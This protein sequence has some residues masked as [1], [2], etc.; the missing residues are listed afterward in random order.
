MTE[1]FEAFKAALD[2]LCKE[3][4][5]R[6]YEEWDYDDCQRVYI[7]EAGE[8]KSAGLDADIQCV[9]PPI[10]PTPEEVAAAAAAKAEWEAGAA[11]REAEY[12]ARMD[13]W[14]ALQEMQRAARIQSPEYL[15]LQVQIKAQAEEQRKKN[16]RVTRIPGDFHDIG[17]KACRV[18]C[19]EVEVSNWI[20]AD[21]F[22]RVVIVPGVEY[23]LLEMAEPTRLPDTVLHGAVRIELAA[24]PA[25]D[26][27]PAVL[28]PEGYVL[29][30]A[31]SRADGEPIACAASVQ[32]DPVPFV[33]TA[34]KPKRIPARKRK[35]GK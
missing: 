2:A 19:N 23:Q 14:R 17:D 1:K 15:A 9:I 10:P 12:Q 8:E 7:E 22:R 25:L 13:A 28:L 20:V 27:H 3:H 4:G 33:N 16:M 35:A 5:V 31:I 11:Q 26:T 30:G 24:A 21:D 6:M 34:A 32:G 18:F 29:S